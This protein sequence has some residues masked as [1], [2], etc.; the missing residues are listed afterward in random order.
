VYSLPTIQYFGYLWVT[1]PGRLREGKLGKKLSLAAA[2][3]LSAGLVAGCGSASSSAGRTAHAAARPASNPN[4]VGVKVHGAWTLQVREPDGRLVRSLQFHNDLTNVGAGGLSSILSKEFTPGYW[5]IELFG[6]PNACLRNSNP[7]SCDISEP[8]GQGVNGPATKNLVLTN[9]GSGVRLKGSTTTDQNGSI[10][11][12]WTVL[13]F[14]AKTVAVAD[15]NSTNVAGFSQ[16]TART[17]P[18][19]VNVQAGQQVLATVDL[20]FS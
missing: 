2:I 5:V 6:S 17:L 4:A 18:S 14:C 19:V 16:I 11:I 15:C 12:V 9:V 3:V 10:T 13:T 20:T 7:A 8:Q 1:S